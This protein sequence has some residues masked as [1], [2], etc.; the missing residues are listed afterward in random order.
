MGAGVRFLGAKLAAYN[1]DMSKSPSTNGANGRNALGQFTVGNTCGRGNPHAK[2]V[3]ALRATMLKAVTHRDLEAIVKQLIK[4]AKD[5]DVLAAREIF[6]RCFGKAKQSV[7]ME[8]DT[9]T[10]RI[11]REFGDMSPEE[12]AEILEQGNNPLPGVLAKIVA[13]TRDESGPAA[14]QV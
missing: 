11:E 9:T 12:L 14:E 13:H 2:K 1:Q 4:Q 10:N 3:A 5:G 6:D 7:D 8:V